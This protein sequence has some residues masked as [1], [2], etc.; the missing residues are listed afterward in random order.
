[1]SGTAMMFAALNVLEGKVV[2]RCMPATKLPARVRRRR[3]GSTY[4]RVVEQ[5]LLHLAGHRCKNPVASHKGLIASV[6][7]A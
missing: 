3:R 5:A 4:W 1:M 7:H 6:A 2:G